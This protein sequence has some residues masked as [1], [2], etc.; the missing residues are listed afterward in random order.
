MTDFVKFKVNEW[1]NKNLIKTEPAITWSE[2]G[3]QYRVQQLCNNSTVKQKV[4]MPNKA[5][6]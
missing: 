2:I 3:A 1:I 5:H 4:N 6:F